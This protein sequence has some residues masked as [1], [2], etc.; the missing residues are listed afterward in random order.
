MRREHAQPQPPAGSRRY[1]G[2]AEEPGTT[3]GAGRGHRPP[4]PAAQGPSPVKLDPRP[5]DHTQPRP[6][7]PSSLDRKGARWG[8]ISAPGPLDRADGRCRCR[9]S[10]A[11]A[12][13]GRGGTARARKCR[14]GAGAAGMAGAAGW[15][16][17]AGRGLDEDANTRARISHWPSSNGPTGPNHA[18]QP[19]QLARAVPATAAGWHSDSIT[20]TVPLPPNSGC[21]PPVQV[22]LAWTGKQSGLTELVAFSR[23]N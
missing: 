1:G 15:V 4:N 6:A 14:R 13:G 18:P 5:P 3:P 23:T 2:G 21:V 16:L 20:H 8:E 7:A 10:A 9:W 19:V 22:R 12:A 17:L 11:A